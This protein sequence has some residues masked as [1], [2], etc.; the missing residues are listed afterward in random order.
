[1][2]AIQQWL[3]AIFFTKEFPKDIICPNFMI[4]DGMNI[5]EYWEYELDSANKYSTIFNIN[6]SISYKIIATFKINDFKNYN[7]LYVYNQDGEFVFKFN[8]TTSTQNNFICSNDFHTQFVP[9]FYI[10]NLKP[11]SYRVAI[12]SCKD[13]VKIL[14]PDLS[15]SYIDKGIN[16][17][18]DGFY[19]AEFYSDNIKECIFYIMV[20]KFSDGTFEKRP[21]YFDSFNR[22]NK[23][24]KL[25]DN[26]FKIVDEVYP[27]NCAIWYKDG[28]TKNYVYPRNLDIKTD[29]LSKAIVT[30]VL[31]NDW[32]V[33]LNC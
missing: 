12:K 8:L 5:V 14:S 9:K 26:R 15:L 31:D 17:N 6:E 16:F 10:N 3:N 25:I 2:D 27:V 13:I 21:V 19:S 30:D 28:K 32:E 4:E 24:Y 11:I 7:I 22:N 20:I 23:P 29:N 1:M 33:D 18:E